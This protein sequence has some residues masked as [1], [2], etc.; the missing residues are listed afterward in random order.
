MSPSTVTRRR[1]ILVVAL[2]VI[3]AA[4]FF[5]PAAAWV[6]GKRAKPFENRPLAGLPSLSRGFG[7]FDGLNQWS[8]DHLPLRADAV[9][10]RSRVYSDV[11]DQLPPQTLAAGPVGIGSTGALGGLVAKANEGLPRDRQ[12]VPGKDGWLFYGQEFVNACRPQAPIATVVAG[13][14]RFSD[15]IRRSGRRLVIVIP[16]DK[17]WMEPQQLPDDLPERACAARAHAAR[18]AALRAARIPGWIDV[19]ALLRR[20]QQQLGRPIYLP[21]DTHW[22]QEGS[23]VYARTVV[24]AL[25]PGLWG[26]ARV[27]P[28]GQA[29]YVPDT[30]RQV[31][32]TTR[33]SEPAF[34]V[35]RPGVPP[36]LVGRVMKLPPY[37]FFTRSTVEGAGDQVIRDPTAVYGDSYDFRALPKLQPFFARLTHIPE[38]IA[39]YLAGQLPQGRRRAIEQ[40]RRARVVVLEQAERIFWG[41]RPA[42]T[43]DPV[44]LD[45]LQQA[46]LGGPQ[47][48]PRAPPSRPDAKIESPGN[49]FP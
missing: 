1:G 38:L 4:F 34:R 3:G 43:W 36:P 20:R 24:D 33:A 44:F 41:V 47:A 22:T 32:D 49:V 29:T 37:W 10:L 26:T 31:G 46:L 35:E 23:L 19:E 5:V 11:F 15:I 45:E 21:R 16:P 48:P 40:I 2:A 8:I 28:D 12:A 39:P 42:A 17:D 18:L 9:R 7:L 30:A 14:R 13:L 25:S 6:S 27:V